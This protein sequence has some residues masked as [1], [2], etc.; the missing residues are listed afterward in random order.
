MFFIIKGAKRHYI[1]ILKDSKLFN[2]NKKSLNLIEY[3]TCNSIDLL[4]IDTKGKEFLSKLIKENIIVKY[5]SIH[6]YESI[7]TIKKDR[8][9][10]FVWIEITNTCNLRCI[11]C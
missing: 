6:T 5:D 8:N 11:H 7:E 2:M 3:I 9:I 10:E 4:D 1:Y